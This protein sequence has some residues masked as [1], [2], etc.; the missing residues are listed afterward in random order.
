MARTV[1]RQRPIGPTESAICSH[2]EASADGTIVGSLGRP[3]PIRRVSN[4]IG[5]L[6]RT[7]GRVVNTDLSYL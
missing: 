1:V 2:H 6:C 7:V 4:A 3:C 5:A